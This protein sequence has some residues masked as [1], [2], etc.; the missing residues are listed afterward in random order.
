MTVISPEA[1]TPILTS[2]SGGTDYLTAF[3]N[4]TSS[5]TSTTSSSTSS[6]TTSDA[7]PDGSLQALPG[8]TSVTGDNS[9]APE[10]QPITEP[11]TSS[12]AQNT[13]T[14][15]VIIGG[16]VIVVLIVGGYFLIRSKLDIVDDVV[17]IA[18]R[19]KKH[20]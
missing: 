19:V 12:L 18:D 14:K 4:T 2:V 16:V 17:D 6:S 10:T 1:S 7:M 13:S 20:L 5:G 9:V 11:A 3:E 8:G 15:N